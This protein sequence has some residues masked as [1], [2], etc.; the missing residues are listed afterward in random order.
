M[1]YLHVSVL[2]FLNYHDCLQV[3]FSRS[4]W[5]PFVCFS[6]GS[7]PGWSGRT[8]CWELGPGF[9]GLA[10]FLALLPCQTQYSSNRT[11]RFITLIQQLKHAVLNPFLTV[12]PLSAF[13]N[14]CL[15]HFSVDMKWQK[16][17]FSSFLFILG[18]YSLDL[19]WG[20]LACT[21]GRSGDDAIDQYLIASC[22]ASEPVTAR[23]RVA[24][25]NR[26]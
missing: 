10:E 12:Q 1:S 18:S 21:C 22:S 15:M 25:G 4:A 11:G 8:C 5:F 16:F 20:C 9:V 14:F 13:H 23:V 2:I 24:V 7:R 3:S 6:P 17:C 26:G 19:I